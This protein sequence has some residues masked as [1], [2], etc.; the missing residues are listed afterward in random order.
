MVFPDRS[1]RFSNNIF[2]GLRDEGAGFVEEYFFK[3]PFE[4]MLNFY[5]FIKNIFY[6]GSP[7]QRTG[8]NI[9]HFF[10]DYF[11]KDFLYKFP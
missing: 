4:Q 11:Y 1:R 2:K 7:G 6:E 10:K 3:S 8:Q 5:V 9:S